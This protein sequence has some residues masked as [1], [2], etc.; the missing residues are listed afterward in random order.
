MPKMRNCVPF[1]CKTKLVDQERA[2]FF[3]D[4]GLFL[5]EMREKTLFAYD[6]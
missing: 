2:V 3:A 6:R 4:T 5:R 1:C